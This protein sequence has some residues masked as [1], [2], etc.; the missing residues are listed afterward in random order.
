[1]SNFWFKKWSQSLRNSASG[2]LRERLHVHFSR[3]RS[4]TVISKVVDYRRWSLTRSGRY[5]SVFGIK[6]NHTCDMSMKL[7]GV[8]VGAALTCFQA[9]FCNWLIFHVF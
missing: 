8:V 3:L 1:M 2:R 4:K 7:H 9:S 6:I 5:E